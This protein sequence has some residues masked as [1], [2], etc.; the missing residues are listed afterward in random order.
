M[1]KKSFLEKEKNDG[2]E[3]RGPG[4]TNTQVNGSLDSNNFCQALSQYLCDITSKIFGRWLVKNVVTGYK[5]FLAAFE[6]NYLVTY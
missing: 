3:S 2:A 6:F 1:K 5:F 4:N